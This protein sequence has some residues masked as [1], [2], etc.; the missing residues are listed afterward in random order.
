MQELNE[1]SNTSRKSVRTRPMS[2]SIAKMA[3]PIGALK[4]AAT[5]PAAPQVTKVLG[6]PWLR[7]DEVVAAL[8]TA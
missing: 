4:V 8:E 5:P 3:P 1:V 7:V 2:T 6:P